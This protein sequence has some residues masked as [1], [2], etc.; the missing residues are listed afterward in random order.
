VNADVLNAL[1]EKLCSGDPDAA[2]QVFVAFEPYLRMVV[3][4]DLTARLRAKLDST[5]VVQS[6]WTDMLSGFRTAGWRFADADHLRAFLVKVTRNRLIDHARRHRPSVERDQP[7]GTT[8][9]EVAPSHD[10]RP[11]E[12]AQA[13]ELWQQ[14]L[15][16]CPPAHH[17]LL[18]LKRDGLALDE[19]AVR[20][21]LHKSSVRRIL[22]ELA[23]QLVAKDRITSLEGAPA[24]ADGD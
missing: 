11:S 4:R 22:Y 3:R 1:L 9:P 6:I 5:D 2:E 13:D 10:P 19:I 23:R 18:R 12:V 21:G 24:A 8:E 17:E 16:L 15:T 7:L 20:T 14:L